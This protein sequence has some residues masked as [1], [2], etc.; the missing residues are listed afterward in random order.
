MVKASLYIYSPLPSRPKSITSSHNHTLPIWK[1]I[2]LRPPP[3]MQ[4]VLVVMLMF[5]VV[6]LFLPFLKRTFTLVPLSASLAC[7]P[8]EAPIIR[9]FQRLVSE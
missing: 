3:F 9:R 1:L 5:V 7:G 2:C 6:F 8:T 4:M